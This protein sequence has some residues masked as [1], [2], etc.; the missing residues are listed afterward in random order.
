MWDFILTKLS[1]TGVEDKSVWQDI[2]ISALLIP[3]SIL[4]FNKLLA[5]WNNKRPSKSI[6][7]NCLNKD[8][9]VFVFHSQM[10]GADDDWNFNPDQKYIT[11]Y[12]GPLSTNQANLRI[13]KKERV[14]PVL[15]K[16]EAE[17]LADVYNILGRI[18]KVKNINVGDLIND[19]NIWSDPI[20]SVGFNPKTLKLIEK[21]NPIYF[22]RNTNELTIKDEDISYNS[23]FPNDIGIVQKTFIKDS[24]NPVFILA[25]IGTTGTSAAGYILKQ[26]LIK[27]GKLFGSDPFCI[28]LKARIDEGK[29]SALID[30]IYPA[31]NWHRII[32]YPLTY[33][34]FRKKNIFKFNI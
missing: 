9:N 33:Y 15:S 34:N 19:W 22:E 26:N 23:E 14:D 12:P 17:C 6:F 5:W 30:K 4:L 10:S 11:R 8:K 25:G 18:G 28:F 3:I 31:P 13:Q 21:C 24:N 16:A 7:K 20:F 27:I 1:I 29:T 32:M 2:F